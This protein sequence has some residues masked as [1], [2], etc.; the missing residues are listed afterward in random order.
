MMEDK[1]S[2]RRNNLSKSLG[3]TDEVKK[4]LTINK[5]DLES[6][7]QDREERTNKIMKVQ[8]TVNNIELKVISSD[9]FFN[10]V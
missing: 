3:Y 8:V 7:R 1:Y 9:K 5:P 10:K 2:Q 6:I 4:S